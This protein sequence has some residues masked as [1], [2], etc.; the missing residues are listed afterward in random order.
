MVRLEQPSDKKTHSH[1]QKKT[2]TGLFFFQ[3]L[4]LF[5]IG[6]R[7]TNRRKQ[8]QVGMETVDII[9]SA[10]CLPFYPEVKDPDTGRQIW[11]MWQQEKPP[12]KPRFAIV[13]FHCKFENYYFVKQTWSYICLD[14][15]VEH[16]I[17]IRRNKRTNKLE[18]WSVTRT[19]NIGDRK[20]VSLV[21]CKIDTANIPKFVLVHSCR[22][23]GFENV[24]AMLS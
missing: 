22:V 6:A 16:Y 1:T 12:A 5:C 15:T 23:H 13:P 10:S 2:H 24:I 9:K 8:T 11:K 19:L 4:L 7:N 17:S 21:E 14:E 3:L 18:P 20:E